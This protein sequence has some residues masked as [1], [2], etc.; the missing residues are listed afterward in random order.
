MLC[1]VIIPTLG[2]STLPRAIDSVLRQPIA[3]EEIEIIIVNDSGKRLDLSCYEY[4]PNIMIINSNRSG[5]AHACNTGASIARG[6]YLQFLHDDDYLLEN[7]LIELLAAACNSGCRWV[8]G[9]AIIVDDD[10]N[11]LYEIDSSNTTG[12]IFAEFVANASPHV[13]YCLIYRRTFLEIGGFT[14]MRSCEDRD[15]FARISLYHDVTSTKVPVTCVI[16]SCG[17]A[18]HYRDMDIRDDYRATRERILDTRHYQ[19]RL[20]DSLKRSVSLRGRVVRQMIFSSILNLK[21]MDV[22]R[23]LD[24]L[25]WSCYFANR[26]VIYPSFWK[27]L[28]KDQS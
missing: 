15:L 9:S 28:V 25:F 27:G 24:R 3:A 14:V 11:K 12:N 2:R 16:R 10:G 20:S 22:F 26:Y 8:I 7:G 4:H 18:S 5:L 1:S 17:Q 6:E 19:R 13:S 23:S 21:N